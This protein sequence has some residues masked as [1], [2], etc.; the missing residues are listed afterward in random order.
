MCLTWAAFCIFLASQQ[1]LAVGIEEVGV[2]C[3]FEQKS[4]ED[5]G[6]WALTADA[7]WVALSNSHEDQG[8]C[9]CTGS[10]LRQREG[11]R[12]NSG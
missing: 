6:L 12:T 11:N 10:G 3:G 8:Q 2:G 4:M 7:G 1:G 9:V 5:P